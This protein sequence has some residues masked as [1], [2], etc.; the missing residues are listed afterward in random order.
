[1]KKFLIPFLLVMVL[2]TQAFAAASV[3][4][5]K[6]DTWGSTKV[7]YGYVTITG[8]YSAGGYSVSAADLGGSEVLAF[9]ATQDGANAD[10][11]N[12]IW[13]YNYSTN[14]LKAYMGGVGHTHTVAA[15]TITCDTLTIQDDDSADSNGGLLYVCSFDGTTA[16][17]E[18]DVAAAAQAMLNDS[19]TAF[20]VIDSTHTMIDT[21]YFD[22][23]YAT[24]DRR[25]MYS[26]NSIKGG[27]DLYVPY[28]TGG[29]ALC[30][31][32]ASNAGASGV[33]VYF[34]HDGS[35]VDERVLCTTANDADAD[36]YGD[37]ARYCGLSLETST[38]ASATT[39]AFTDEYLTGTALSA[40]VKFIAIV[41]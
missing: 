2:G 25:L 4:I 6:A 1:M 20:A 11:Y 9:H 26:G 12:S 8:N 27:N 5:T 24:A 18:A 34:D 41:R 32:Y 36:V 15:N 37:D 30:V 16:W 29:K 22:D 33:A 40:T 19:S 13:H 39:T 23:D 3:T 21:V 31:R 14:Y 38:S 35:A 28:G 7:V 17:F 10:A